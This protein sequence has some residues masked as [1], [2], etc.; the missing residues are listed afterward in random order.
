MKIPNSNSATA[1]A[2][3]GTESDST[4]RRTA[5]PSPDGA[6]AAFTVDG[7]GVSS[8]FASAVTFPGAVPISTPML[9]VGSQTP[10]GQPRYFRQEARLRRA[11]S[12]C[13]DGVGPRERL[14]LPRASAASVLSASC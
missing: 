13:E 9:I 5:S 2:A 8:A 3:A 10:F 7:A 14:A 6:V 12:P 1:N 11:G 4:A